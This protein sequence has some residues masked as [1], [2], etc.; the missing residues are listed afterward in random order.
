MSEEELPFFV[1]RDD[2]IKT[3][4]L[5]NSKQAVEYDTVD[6]E[7]NIG[8]WEWAIVPLNDLKQL[9]EIISEIL[10]EAEE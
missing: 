9:Q 3:W 2:R 4:L 1:F 6:E 5:K 7:F 10:K 8:D